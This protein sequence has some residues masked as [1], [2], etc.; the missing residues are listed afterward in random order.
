MKHQCLLVKHQEKQK[1]TVKFI[2]RTEIP[3]NKEIQ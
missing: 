3:E 1:T 2:E